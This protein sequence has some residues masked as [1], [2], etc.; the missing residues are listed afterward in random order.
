M[1]KIVFIAGLEHSGTTILDVLVGGGTGAVALGEV[2]SFINSETRGS[3]LSRFGHFEDAHLCSCG[4][5]HDECLVWSDVV[6]YIS[7][8]PTSDL[9]MRYRKVAE[10]VERNFGTDLMLSDSSKSIG[11]LGTV[12]EVA[13]GRPGTEVRILLA[14]KDVRSFVSSM[15]QV[16]KLN[17]RGQ[18]SCFRW[19][20][21]GNA[22][23]L[24][25]LETSGI[26]YH[27]VLY[28]ALCLRTRLTIK[29][30]RE[31]LGVKGEDCVDGPQLRHARER[32][33]ICA[34]NA[35]MVF[36]NRDEIRYDCRW[37]NQMSIN[38]LYG[39]SREP[40]RMNQQFLAEHLQI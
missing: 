39:L 33:H 14:V 11:A 3:F 30:I 18:F 23:F 34:G 10:S 21:G 37:F 35:D 22:Q 19:W 17:V 16:R 15:T 7:E 6:R 26:P 27:V 1:T 24:S 13:Q 12:L 28:E 31:F 40:R 20:R 32:A 25:F 8:N 2:S 5:R 36:R 4:K 38:M 29:G 9:V